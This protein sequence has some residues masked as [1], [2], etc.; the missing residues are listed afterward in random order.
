M[1]QITTKLLTLDDV[2]LNKDILKQILDRLTAYKVRG[3]PNFN[4]RNDMPGKLEQDQITI[5]ENELKQ[6]ELTKEIKL[7]KFGEMAEINTT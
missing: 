4:L 1:I 5:I 6:P 7:E 2:R 3:R